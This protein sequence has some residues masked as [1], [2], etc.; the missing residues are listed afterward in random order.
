MHS[1][2][3]PER[4]SLDGAWRFQLLERPTD[5]PGPDWSQADVPGLWTMAGTFGTPRTTPTSRCPSPGA[6]PE[7]PD[8]NPTGSTSGVRDPADWA[9][10]RVVLHVGAA[11]SVLIVSLDGVEVGVGKDAHLASEFD[12]TPHLRP[13]LSTLRLKV[14][15]WSDASTS[16]TRI[17]G[18]TAGSAGSVLPVRDG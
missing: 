7:L 13:G 8:I 14:V 17:S 2:A 4:L 15:K 5:E 3:H 12:I 1:L 18:G 10:R 9:G 6:A 16:R 11:E